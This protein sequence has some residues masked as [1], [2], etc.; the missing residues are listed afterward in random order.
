MTVARWKSAF[1]ALV[2]VLVLFGAPG[3]ASA[4]A[5]HGDHDGDGGGKAPGPGSAVV[6]TATGPDGTRVLVVG[7]SGAGFYPAGSALYTP[8]IDPVVRGDDERYKPGCDATTQAVSVLEESQDPAVPPGGPYPPF[9]CAGGENDPT[10]DWPALTTD[11]APVAGPG[12]DPRRL[13]SVYRRDLDA[14]QVTYGGHPLYLF[15]PG[16]GSFA[17]QDFLETVP[18]LFPWHTAW[19][20]VSS[21]GVVDPG[22]AGLVVQAPQAGTDYTSPVLSATMIPAI[23]GLPTTVYTLDD[24]EHGGCGHGCAAQ[25]VPLLT[26][27]T[28]TAGPGVDAG[29]IGTVTRHDGTE[30]VTYDGEPL[31]LFMQEVAF[32]GVAGPATTGNGAGATVH[33]RTLEYVTP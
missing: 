22:V 26:T 12:V 30:Q 33:D 23:G 28:P 24:A 4:H 1:A 18:P 17:G 29:A 13:G 5:W 9:T 19:Y 20:L 10:A 21:D 16:P 25:L 7:G 27:G 31:F 15:D 3:V 32:L 8:T 11:G 2:G 14:R 6:T